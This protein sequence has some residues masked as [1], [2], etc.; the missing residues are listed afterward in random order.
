MGIPDDRT[1]PPSPSTNTNFTRQLT[2]LCFLLTKL[3]SLLTIVWRMV[4]FHGIHFQFSF[5]RDTKKTNFRNHIRHLYFSVTSRYQVF[6]GGTFICFTK[7]WFF[8]W[9]SKIKEE[10]PQQL[11]VLVVVAVVTYSDGSAKLF[12]PASSR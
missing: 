11:L 7:K 8:E 6:F 2:S 10:S 12:R 3:S 5:F 1:K 9:R 4:A